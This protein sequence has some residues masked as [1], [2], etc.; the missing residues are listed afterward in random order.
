MQENCRKLAF[1]INSLQISLAL[2]HRF[3]QPAT[4]SFGMQFDGGRNATHIATPKPERRYVCAIERV[5]V[6]ERETVLLYLLAG[7]IYIKL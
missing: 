5:P 6:G 3:R 4:N 1:H 7:G 2:S